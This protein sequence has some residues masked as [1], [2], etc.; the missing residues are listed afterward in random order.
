MRGGP[1]RANNGSRRSLEDLVGACKQSPLESRYQAPLP[2]DLGLCPSLLF[3]ALL[4]LRLNA[5][6]IEYRRLLVIHEDDFLLCDQ[7]RFLLSGNQMFIASK[8]RVF[9]RRPWIVDMHRKSGFR[10]NM[11]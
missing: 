3:D 6:Q 10:L 7:P 9:L 4:K 11:R 1:V 8:S 2:L 5:V